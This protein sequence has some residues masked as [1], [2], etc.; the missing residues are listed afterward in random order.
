M[1]KRYE[2]Y[3]ITVKYING[4]IEDINL[5]GINTSNHSAMLKVYH[6][7]KSTYADKVK[8]IDFVGVSKDGSMNVMWTKEIKPTGNIE[9]KEDINVIMDNIS[10]QMQLIKNKNFYHY[11]LINVLN[12]KED[13][14]LHELEGIKEIKYMNEL[15]RDKLRL[16]IAK[17][18]E[19]M[20][21]DRRWHKDQLE[22]I[23]K[24]AECKIGNEVLNF[25]HL[26]NVFKIKSHKPEM[27]PLNMK[28][29]EELKLY[30]E[31]V[32]KDKDKQI[33]KLKKSYD[34]VIID[35]VENKIICYNKAKVI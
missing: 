21:L 34:K 27:K 35:P 13:I 26:S 15:D 8:T 32:I 5:M 9:L 10:K 20:R 11:D 1:G 23:N 4:D 28:I 30:K 29:A 31:E 18:I 2:K 17:E 14:K 33:E 19:E 22:M 7:I 16:K 6:R 25:T 24:L 3:K 12:K